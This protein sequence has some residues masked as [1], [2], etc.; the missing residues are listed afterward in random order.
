MQQGF[1]Q[2]QPL[3]VALGKVAR[4]P[5]GIIGQ[6]HA[7]DDLAYSLWR[8]AGMQAAGDFQVLED[9]QLRIGMRDLHQIADRCPGF[10]AAQA[11]PG[12]QHLGIPGGGFDHPQQHADGGG[13]PGAIQPQESVDLSLGHP[14]REVL[15]GLYLPVVFPQVFGF[16]R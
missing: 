12:L 14:Q 6:P 15:D 5:V 10:P 3:G 13:F 8:G 2:S 1:G 11:H 16:N 7:F 9:R 4:P